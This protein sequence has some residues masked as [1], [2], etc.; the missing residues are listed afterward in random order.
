MTTVYGDLVRYRELFGNL[1]RR[2]VQAK[3]QG[4]LLGLAWSLANPAPADGR[5]PAGLLVLWQRR[6][7][8]GQ[9]P[10][11][12]SWS[13]SPPGSSSPVR[14][15][16]VALD[17]RQREPHPQDALSAPARPVVGR[18]HE[19]H[20]LHRHARRAA[21]PQLRAV[22]ARARDRVAGDPAR[23]RDR[24]V[25]GRARARRGVANV[26]FRDIEF[27]VAALLLPC[28]S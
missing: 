18:R 24:R 25:H 17:A 16:V 19:P 13:G 23:G 8:R 11:S 1:F 20:Q 3:Y 14:P 4:S 10:R 21:R 15:G 6:S 9:L 5:L 2:D 26:L 22:A 28:S 7:L 12:S 27:L